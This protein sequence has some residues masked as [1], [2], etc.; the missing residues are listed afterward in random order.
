MGYARTM[1]QGLLK[2]RARQIFRNAFTHLP[3]WKKYLVRG[4]IG[5]AGL[6]VVG[7]AIAFFSSGDGATGTWSWSAL[8]TGIGCLLGFVVGAAVRLFLKLGL[9][10]M[11]VIALVLFGISSIGW[12]DLPWDTLAE[13]TEA[14]GG[15]FTRQTAELHTALTGM[16][17]SSAAS[18][19]GLFAGATQRP[20]ADDDD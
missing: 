4:G 15:W 9:M 18:G 1:V 3:G 17:P 12:I 13:T 20:L 7:Q 5:L 2:S 14:L 10:L 16:L 11:G 6:G 8:G 19:V